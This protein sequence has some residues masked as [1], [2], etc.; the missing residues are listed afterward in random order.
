[1]TKVNGAHRCNTHNHVNQSA[2]VARS[3]KP[4]SPQQQTTYQRSQ[5]ATNVNAST[6]PARPSVTRNIE[7][8]APVAQ[9]QPRPRAAQ[10]N[11]S[12]PLESVREGNNMLRR[13][14]SGPQVRALQD[15]LNKVGATPP[16][17]TDGKFGPLTQAA[18]RNFQTQQG[19]SV[20]GVV[21]PQTMGKL[22]NPGQPV[23][24]APHNH[25]HATEGPAAANGHNHSQGSSQADAYDRGRNIGRI[26]VTQIDGKPVEVRTADAFRRMREA[27]AQDG[28]NIR[29]NSGFRSNSEQAELYRRYQN[30][31]GNL[32]ARPGHSNHQNGRALD[33]NTR[34]ASVLNW[35]N[36][37]AARFGFERTVPSE[38]WHWEHRH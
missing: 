31:T 28:V 38:P 27:A 8:A 30:G 6:T 17:D 34:D 16:L 19:I 20:D 24:A 33:L 32:A 14:A 2:P 10:V 37:N 21:G 3:N 7:G 36:R 9:A 1:M 5:P 23:A 18:V 26:D 25:N 13:G 15:M 29:I 35:L 12:Q 11:R 4:Q 22:D